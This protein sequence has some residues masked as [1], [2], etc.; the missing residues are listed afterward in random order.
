[1]TAIS[2]RNIT[3]NKESFC[4]IVTLNSLQNSSKGALT[5]EIF[6]TLG[7]KFRVSARRYN[8]LYLLRV[9][10]GLTVN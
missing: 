8:I 4:S 3:L 5:R 6:S 10:M 9:R 7:E 1:M 2:L